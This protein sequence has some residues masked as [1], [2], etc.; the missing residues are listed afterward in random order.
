MAKYLLSCRVMLCEAT[1][2]TSISVGPFLNKRSGRFGPVV[3]L[4][5][6]KVRFGIVVVRT[7]SERVQFCDSVC[8]RI[9]NRSLTLAPSIVLMFYHNCTGI[10]KK[11]DNICLSVFSVE[12]RCIVV[13]Y[14]EYASMVVQEFKSITLLN[15][16]AV[17]TK[18]PDRRSGLE[19]SSFSLLLLH[20]SVVCLHLRMK[21]F[22]EVAFFF[23]KFFHNSYG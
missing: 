2:F 16:V 21:G 10:V 9:H 1:F 3:C 20:H 22:Y 5:E 6:V 7:V 18:K 15:Q 11:S 8:S 14:S 13:L 12:I 4:K 19:K 17:K 23:R